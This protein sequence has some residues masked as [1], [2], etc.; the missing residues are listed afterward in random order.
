[1]RIRE[2]IE[3]LQQLDEA[4]QGNA[5]ISANITEEHDPDRKTSGLCTKVVIRLPWLY[6]GSGKPISV[7]PWRVRS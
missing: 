6:M 1:M 3:M 5:E 4:S 2:L 7:A